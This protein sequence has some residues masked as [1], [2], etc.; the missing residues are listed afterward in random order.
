[1]KEGLYSGVIRAVAVQL[2]APSLK[3]TRRMGHSKTRVSKVA[4]RQLAL[5]CVGRRQRAA[6]VAAWSGFLAASQ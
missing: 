4:Q 5:R 1:M 2:L 6:A 3:Q